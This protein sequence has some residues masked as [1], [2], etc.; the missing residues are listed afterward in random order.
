MEIVL[1]TIAAIVLYIAADRG[2]N[3]VEMRRGARFEHRSFIF[4]TI[5]VTLAVLSFGL[6]QKVAGV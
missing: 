4:F 5:L 2:L 6:I 1:F 3:Y